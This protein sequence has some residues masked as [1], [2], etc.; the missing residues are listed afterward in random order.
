MDT[1][2]KEVSGIGAEYL[3]EKY[4]YVYFFL[5]SIAQISASFWLRNYWKSYFF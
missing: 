4:Y 3:F 5:K 1:D 2:K